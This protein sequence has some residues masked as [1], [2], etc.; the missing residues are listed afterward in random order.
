MMAASLARDDPG[1]AGAAH[2]GAELPNCGD[3]LGSVDQS[4]QGG[5][6]LIERKTTERFVAR[7]WCW[8]YESFSLG[9]CHLHG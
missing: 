1:A 9:H 6:R 3:L 7:S 8:E 5:G 4:H 2:D